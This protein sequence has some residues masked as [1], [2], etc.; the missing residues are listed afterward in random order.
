[1]AFLFL[2]QARRTHSLSDFSRKSLAHAPFELLDACV[3]AAM[4]DALS[5][6]GVP[7][8]FS[9]VGKG[10]ATK[11]KRRGQTRLASIRLSFDMC[12]EYSVDWLNALN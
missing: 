2:M 9:H 12:G 1:M 6:V 4:P 7:L 10:G 5:I 3:G 11:T 8:R